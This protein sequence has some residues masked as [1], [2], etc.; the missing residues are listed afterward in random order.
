MFDALYSVL[1]FVL[2]AGLLHALLFTRWRNKSQRFWK[3]TDYCWLSVALL[4][5][6][7]ISEQY[8]KALLTQRIQEAQAKLDNEYSA[9]QARVS[10]IMSMQIGIALEKL[11]KE[12]LPLPSDRDWLSPL[13]RSHRR[14]NILL[15][16]MSFQRPHKA[17]ADE[18]RRAVA[19]FDDGINH[20]LATDG[21]KKMLA[22]SIYLEDEL[23]RLRSEAKSIRFTV[24]WRLLAPIL[25][26]FALALRITRVTA[27]VF[28][29]RSN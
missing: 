15:Q 10:S 27:D 4:G 7:G 3:A 18:I 17:N 25:L 16:A 1:A 11:S 22:R 21:A 19:A 14:L 8:E 23:D 5:L 2:F 26:A 24:N 29:M 13:V 28:V 9:Q 6:W 12:A 20:E